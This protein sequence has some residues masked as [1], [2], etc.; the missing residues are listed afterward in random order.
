MISKK[1]EEGELSTAFAI[2]FMDLIY[3]I[4]IR[5]PIDNLKKAIYPE[6]NNIEQNKYDI[7]SAY[8]ILFAQLAI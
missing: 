5:D 1:A 7:S 8:Q 3:Y 2:V 6:W 4:P